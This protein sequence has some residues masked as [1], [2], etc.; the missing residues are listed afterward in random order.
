MASAASTISSS[1]GA[2]GISHL[3]FNT[4]DAG[5]QTVDEHS[6]AI[7]TFREVA[8]VFSPGSG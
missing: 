4:M 7:R 1:T 6:A 8:P 3:E 2:Q 5:L